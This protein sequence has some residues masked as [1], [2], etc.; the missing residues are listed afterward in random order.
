MKVFRFQQNNGIK[1]NR[2]QTIQFSG[3]GVTKSISAVVRNGKRLHEVFPLKAGT[4]ENEDKKGEVL[5][6]ENLQFF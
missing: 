6:P 3:R 5:S 4:V 1:A 2:I